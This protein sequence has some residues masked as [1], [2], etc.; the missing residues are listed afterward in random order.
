MC[1]TC[2]TPDPR[3]VKLFAW[4]RLINESQ[5]EALRSVLNDDPVEDEDARILLS[6]ASESTADRLSLFKKRGRRL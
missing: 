2:Y 1:V 3:E 4:A 6:V 5:L